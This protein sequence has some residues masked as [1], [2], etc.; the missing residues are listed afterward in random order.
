MSV[1]EVGL[2]SGT[3]S[4]LLDVVK[5]FQSGASLGAKGLGKQVDYQT[6][7]EFSKSSLKIGMEY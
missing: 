4:P 6:D 1:F 5:M 3:T 7:S 2:E